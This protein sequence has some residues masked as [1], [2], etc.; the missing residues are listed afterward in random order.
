MASDERTTIAELKSKVRK[1]REQRGWLE[2]WDA[3]NFVISL[4]L[5]ASELL[6]HFQWHT[7]REV[8]GNKKK[9]KE[10]ATRCR[11]N[12]QSSLAISLSNK[13]LGL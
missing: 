4:V 8:F 5:E 1:F 9:S 10:A 11:P 7:A 13:N 3:R 6:E 12:F 2:G